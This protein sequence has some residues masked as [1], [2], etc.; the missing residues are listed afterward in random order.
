MVL[1]ELCP[2]LLEPIMIV[3]L[4]LAPQMKESADIVH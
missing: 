2:A 1:L 4:A 3:Q